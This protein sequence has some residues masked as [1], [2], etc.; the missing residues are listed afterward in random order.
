MA[1]DLGHEGVL[2]LD[3][4]EQLMFGPSE[5]VGHGRQYC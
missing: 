2:G 3:R 5:I 1:G 4:D